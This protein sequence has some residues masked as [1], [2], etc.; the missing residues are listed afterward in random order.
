MLMKTKFDD[1]FHSTKS[2]ELRKKASEELEIKYRLPEKKNCKKKKQN[3]D[4]F[5]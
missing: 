5:N 2:E 3:F 4:F 1:I